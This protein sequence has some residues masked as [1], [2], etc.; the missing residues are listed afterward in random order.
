MSK[1]S[2][3]T[4]G[5]IGRGVKAAPPAATPAANQCRE[6]RENGKPCHR[7]NCRDADCRKAKASAPA[8]SS[9]PSAPAKS[10]G[11]GDGGVSAQLSAMQSQLLSMHT[12]VDDLTK[13]V[14][15]GFTDTKSILNDQQQASL[16]MQKAL[17]AIMIA[18]AN[19]QTGFTGL[20]KG[21]GGGSASRPE[22]PAPPARLAICAS[23]GSTVTE[24]SEEQSRQYMHSCFNSNEAGSGM[25]ATSSS[26]RSQS[27]VA[28]DGGSASNSS[29][30]VISKEA[31]TFFRE[32][33]GGSTLVAA[34]YL[35]NFEANFSKMKSNDFNSF[36]GA[37]IRKFV[38]NFV[39]NE[40]DEMACVLLGMV[41]GKRY[42]AHSH[43][44]IQSN[45]SVF[46][47]FFSD[48]AEKFSN[49]AVKTTNNRGQE[50]SFPFRR[51]ST[52]SSAMCVL[53]RVLRGEE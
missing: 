52:D 4:I 28:S 48:L 13:Q 34:R 46:R 25:S 27:V 50:L 43:I 24:V 16:G 41:N 2:F 32:S 35:Q 26:Q 44:I 51:L 5:P 30:F 45:E 15:T 29:Q 53:I 8:A 3:T 40:Q 11:G 19:L 14:A 31:P 10:A 21:K 42:P 36:I 38:A 6:F 12:K 23:G 33:S 22:L 17:E 20:L 9:K 37:A 1:A 49:N 47:R 18:S 39:Y 7:K